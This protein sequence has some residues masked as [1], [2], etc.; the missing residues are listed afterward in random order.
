MDRRSIRGEPPVRARLNPTGGVPGTPRERGVTTA[1]HDEHHDEEIKYADRTRNGI[2]ASLLLGAI[3]F[4]A[5]L[6]TEFLASATNVYAIAG[7]F[8]AMG[9]GVIVAGWSVDLWTV[10][11]STAGGHRH[12]ECLAND[13]AEAKRELAYVRGQLAEL[14]EGLGILR[15]EGGELRTLIEGARNQVEE[16]RRRNS[17]R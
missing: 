13:L 2:K 14:I 7:G 4:G 16:Q 5:G 8:T 17:G 6:L 9:T 12:Y 10:G 15:N 1:V 3:I 11:A